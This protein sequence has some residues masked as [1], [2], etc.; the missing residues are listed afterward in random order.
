MR[1]RSEVWT[2]QKARK[3]RW[4]CLTFIL[5]RSG[6]YTQAPCISRL[7]FI[8]HDNPLLQ[9]KRTEKAVFGIAPE[10]TW[11]RGYPRSPIYLWVSEGCLRFRAFVGLRASF[12]PFM[13]SIQRF[14]FVPK[15]SN[16]SPM[17][18]QP[19][20]VEQLNLVLSYECFLSFYGLAQAQE[21]LLRLNT[22]LI[23]STFAKAP[24]M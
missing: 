5:T 18:M 3:F 13:F 1:P 23:C 22:I 11:W 10:K 16:H 9:L 8:P 20:S 15:I 21:W 4:R 17:F 24:F 7:L 14:S 6:E 19:S 12:R 2:L